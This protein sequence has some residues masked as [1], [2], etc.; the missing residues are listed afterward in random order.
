L[1]GK[2][3]WI[4][5]A[6]FRRFIDKQ[7]VIWYRRKQCYLFVED[8]VFRVPDNFNM[9]FFK[10][11]IWTLVDSD[12]GL[13]KYLRAQDTMHFIILTSSPRKQ[14]WEALDKTTVLS[15][16][17][18]NPWSKK[19]ISKAW[20]FLFLS[21][22]MTSF[23]LCSALAHELTEDKWPLISDTY[24]RFGPTPRLCFRAVTDEGWL[25]TYR[26]EYQAALS[27]LTVSR[28]RAMVSEASELDMNEVS[29]KSFLVRRQDD[30]VLQSV[31]LV[32]ITAS[33]EWE[34]RK[35]L[36]ELR[37]NEQLEL[38]SLFSGVTTS[39]TIA[40]ILFETMAQRKLQGG[41]AL[42]LIPM[43]IAE[44]TSSGQ[45]RKRRKR[46]QWHSKH[47][48]DSF[49]QSNILSM[50]FTPTRVVEYPGSKLDRIE[51]GIYYVPQSRTQ[52]TFDS[53]VVKDDYLYL[54]Q[55]SIASHHL[56]KRGI[57]SFFSQHSVPPMGMWRFVFAIPIGSEMKCPQPDSQ[58]REM[59]LFTAEVDCDN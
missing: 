31:S 39:R 45:G 1:K 43:E 24:D 29:H 23:W 13:P 37:K 9:D 47:K 53:F 50:D 15:S 27:F 57:L 46:P 36:R 34:L 18:M 32:P 3:W 44:S 8:G 19:E 16:V 41:S 56:I 51:P 21:R 28:L 38:Y 12:D 40:G 7:P 35:R 4:F 30:D 22:Y 33:V 6:L 10:T 26:R 55:F 54:F 17:I 42:E 52:V 2:S 5:Y 49:S 25:V 11:F 59:E 20:V 14:R 48:S 58:L